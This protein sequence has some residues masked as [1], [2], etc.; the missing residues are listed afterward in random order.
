[1]LEYLTCDSAAQDE[2][3]LN[4]SNNTNAM[5]Q[6]Q[7]TISCHPNDTYNGVYIRT[8]D[9]GGAPH[10]ETHDGSRQLYYYED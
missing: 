10:F 2:S 6:K 7:L 4:D 3:E 9:W 8:E 5:L 1:M